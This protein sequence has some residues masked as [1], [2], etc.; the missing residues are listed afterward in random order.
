MG[1]LDPKPQTQAG[2]DTAV[3]DKITTPGTETA[4][5]LNATILDQTEPIAAKVNNRPKIADGIFAA[6]SESLKSG[7]SAAVQLQGDST[8][9]ASYEWYYLLTQWLRDQNPTCHVKYKLWNDTTQAYDGWTVVQAGA[10]GERHAV[11]L[12]ANITRTFY[13][14]QTAIPH[15]GGDID[16]RARLAM[17]DWTP[18][19]TAGIVTRY[20]A[21]GARA[22][23]L[24]INTAG[25]IDFTWTT[26]GT[27]NIQK[28]GTALGFADGTEG[29]VRV[30]LDVDNG[31]GGYTWKAYKSTDGVAW[32]EVGSSVTTTGG[33]T[34][35]F[36]AAQEY[37]IGGRGF[38]GEAWA[39]KMYE[40]QIRDGIDGKIVNAQPIDSWRPRGVSGTYVAGTFGGSPTLYVLNGSNPGAAHGYFT[41]AA[42]HPKMVHPYTGSLLFQS[43]SHND[44]DNTGNTYLAARD[45]WLDLNDAR[46]PGSQTVIVTQNPQQAP[47]G[48]DLINN[49]AR[50]RLL[51]MSWAAR[52]G[53]A[54]IDTYKAFREDSRG[55]S[56]LLE[57]DGIHPNTVG[58]QLWADTVTGAFAAAV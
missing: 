19:A 2:L 26:D 25:A 29:W 17:D 43:C 10:A 12:G 47:I 55:L 51:L 42:R 3:R 50:R 54:T 6:V 27:T 52:K 45:S 1:F 49:H 33:A 28:V 57:T 34:S 16:I 39:G 35:I 8:G 58:S 20:G 18:A 9:N 41:D 5:A 48:D 24:S 4:T 7:R 37:E 38:A 13:T 40:V 31:Q 36:D 46:V 15:I 11:F 21:A 32:T 30:T 14:P 44:G 23:K 53:I 22:W 56:A